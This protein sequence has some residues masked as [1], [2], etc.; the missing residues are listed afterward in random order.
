MNRP[1]QESIHKLLLNFLGEKFDITPEQASR[2]VPLRELGL[3]SMLVL[4]VIMEMEDKLGTRLDDLTI[5]RDATLADVAAMIQR[6]L[7]A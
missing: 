6:N 2:D 1:N 3:D 5:P 7:D 4:D